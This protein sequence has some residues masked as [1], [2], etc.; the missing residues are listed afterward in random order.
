MLSFTEYRMQPYIVKKI[1][2]KNGASLNSKMIKY[3][4]KNQC[5]LAEKVPF[6]SEA[7]IRFV[8]WLLIMFQLNP[9]IA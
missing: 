1:V 4:M 3:S 6:Y 7:M 9:N 8:V 2:I 5:C